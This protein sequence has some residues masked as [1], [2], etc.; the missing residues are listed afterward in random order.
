[1]I[2]ALSLGT[3]CLHYFPYEDDFSL[4]RY[5]AI[6]NSPVPITWVTRG[7]SEYFAND[8]QCATRYFGFDRPVANATFYIESLF[9]RSAEGPLLLMT[10]VLCW[11]VSA[12]FIYGIARR[13]GASTWVASVG[14]LLYALSPCW[15]R[16][17][18][19][20]SFR[21]N[22]LAACFL[23]AA[24]YVLLKQDAMRSWL[25]LVVAGLFLALAA[26]SH[27]QGFTSLPVFAVGVAWLS[28]KT[29]D[30]WR[31]GRIVFAVTAVVAPSLLV[32]GCFRLMNPMY[33]SSYVTTGFM[34]SLTQSRHLTSFGIHSHLLIG[35]IKLTI[36]VVGALISALTAFT[37]VGGENLAQ[38]SPYLGTIIFVLT[39]VA[40]V[41]IMKRFPGQVLPVAA[42]VLYAVGRSFGIPSAEPRFTHMEVAW[43]IIALVCALSAGLAANNRIAITAGV[44]AALGLF[45]FNVVSYNATILTRRSV[46]QRRNEVDREAFHRIQT[47]ASKYPDAQVVLVNDHA[48][49]ESSRAMLELSGFEGHDFEILPTIMD[50]PSIDTLRDLTACQASTQLMRLSTNLQIRLDYPAGCAVYFFGRDMGCILDQYKTAG[51][52]HSAAWAEFMEHLERQGKYPP[53]L[54]HDVPIQTAR[55]LAVITWRERLSVP[56]VTTMPN[57]SAVPPAVVLT[58]D[59]LPLAPSFNG[60]SAISEQHLG[61]TP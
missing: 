3:Y 45:A 9:Y 6:Q 50:A 18:I 58:S 19:H 53:P 41:A 14:I 55:P 25:R 43:G 36:R 26:G 4:I 12:W 8:P 33:G 22:G 7:F 10:N 28:F 56:D 61:S 13:L 1:M 32:L 57:Y 47:A 60:R 2:F 5:S 27:E 39:I 17:Q 20:A 29:E 23:L 37:P 59:F 52:F 46:L 42:L 15:Y 48:G 38:L 31:W 49:I 40:S 16:V 34:D 35:T 54:I 30:R 44:A 11:I 51:R 21:N 24:S